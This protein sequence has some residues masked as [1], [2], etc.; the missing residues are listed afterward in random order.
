MLESKF[1]KIGHTFERVLINHS[2]T[3]KVSQCP[4]RGRLIN[5]DLR[6]RY[7]RGICLEGLCKSMKAF[8]QN[9]LC[10]GIRE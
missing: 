4:V 3:T 7:C 2:V 10:P 1:V 9:S 5:C 6:K 8:S